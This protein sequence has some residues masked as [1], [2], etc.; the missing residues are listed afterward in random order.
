MGRSSRLDGW[1]LIC[2]GTM[3]GWSSCIAAANGT[4][5]SPVDFLYHAAPRDTLIGIGRRL[6]LEPRRWHEIQQRNGIADPRHIPL[7]QVLRIPYAWLKLDVESATVVSLAGQVEL[8]GRKLAIGELLPQG[9][10]VRTGS[11]GSVTLDL[12]DGSV[13]TLQKSSVLKLDQMVAVTGVASARSIV[14]KLDAGRVETT[15]KPHRDVGRFEI[16]TPV[17]VSAVRGTQ[18]R[19]SFTDD[20]A[21]G[22][23]ETLE[24]SVGVGNDAASVAVAAGFGTRVEP[25]REPLPPV[26]LL[27]APDLSQVQPVNG[28]V[29]L[30]V[31]WSPV[32]GARQ[33]RAQVAADAKFRALV[34]DSLTSSPAVDLTAPPDGEYWLRVRSIDALGLEG[35]DAV[36]AFTQHSLP[37]APQLMSPAAD[38]KIVGGP[39]HLAW[40]PAVGASSYALQ[41]A[42]DP[43]F[44]APLLDRQNLA[45]P[46]S[47][48]AQLAAGRY[49]WRTRSINTGGE[50]GPWSAVRSFTQRPDMTMPD[51]RIEGR[52][53]LVRW[54]PQ[55]GETYRIQIARDIGFVHA[56]IDRP[57]EAAEWSA[58]KPFPGVYYC[59]VQ[60]IDSDGSGGAYSPPRRF[61]VP[62]P[63]WV[64]VAAPLAIGLAFLL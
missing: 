48:L 8:D 7:G 5:V 40:V 14:L 19:D 36:R 49:F 53:V 31:Q 42:S 6:L 22:T 35:P 9:S 1:R 43:S 60:S 62:I 63:L 26:V 52:R 20:D 32:A 12:A 21:H 37:A 10:V 59:R 33:Y 25:N 13:V 58:S 55:P 18:F 17:A 3:V 50:A 45:S 29:A 51:A 28:D 56:F 2:A 41:V 34:V 15:V 38:A 24:G 11:D 64:K 4:A 27:P 57:V 47:D 46:A 16:I 54:Q 23:T 61:V 39:A 44:N 30:N